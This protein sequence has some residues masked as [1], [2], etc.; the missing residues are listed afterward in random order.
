MTHPLFINL[1][2]QNDRLDVIEKRRVRG[3]V[4]P[5]TCRPPVTSKVDGHKRDVPLHQGFCHFDVLPAMFPKAMNDAYD[6]FGLSV[7]SPFLCVQRSPIAGAPI[8]FVDLHW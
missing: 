4:A 8:K 3:D 6:A 2:Y 5:A 1:C 7:R